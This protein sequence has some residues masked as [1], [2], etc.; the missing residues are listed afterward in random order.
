MCNRV[1]LR[2]PPHDIARILELFNLPQQAARFNIAPTE[3]L[4]LFRRKGSQY[5]ACLAHWGLQPSWIKNSARDVSLFN[6]RAESADTK[7][8]FHEAFF[9]R[10][11]LIPVDGFYEW[12]TRGKKKIP[13][14]YTMKDARPYAFAGLYETSPD[15]PGKL[16]CTILTTESNELIRPLHDRMPVI[17]PEDRYKNWLDP[18]E[19]D[20][21][22]L[23]AMLRP[24]DP[25]K[26]MARKVNPYV[27]KSGNEGPQCLN[28]APAEPP[29]T[30]QGMLFE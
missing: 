29:Q 14:H 8:V 15:D 18:D 16:S 20:A 3:E 22:A 28:D 5:D 6:A 17:L 9:Q 12:E 30:V 26:M 13:Y 24:F 1:T 23:K 7:P 2:E 25:S 4:L 27:N 10:R 21:Q 11:C 19:Q